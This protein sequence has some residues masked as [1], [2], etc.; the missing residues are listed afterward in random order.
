MRDK[1]ISLLDRLLVTHSPSGEEGE[2]EGIVEEL[3][4]GCC[5]SV[6]RDP[7]DNIMAKI[8][9]R[10]SEDATLV[11]AHKDEIGAIVHTIDD[12]GLLRLE[13]LG[14]CVPW[15]YGEGPW[16]VLGDEVITG[17][18]SVGSKHSTGESPQ[19]AAAKAGNLHW[20][21]CYIDCKLSK[22]EL[23]AK[24]VR[25]GTRACVARSRKT[26]MLLGDCI[27]GYALDDKASVAM[28]VLLAR[29]IHESGLRP[30][31][32]LYLAATS[33]EE[34]GISGGAYAAAH[35]P[36][37]EAIALEIAPV[38]PEYPI[39]MSDQP[40]IFYKDAIFVYHK[41]LSDRLCFTG[42]N[43]GLECQPMLVRS[44]GSDVSTAVKYGHIGRAACVGFPTEN[45]HGYEIGHLGAMENCVKLL[46][47]YLMGG[48]G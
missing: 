35:V 27:A 46:Q 32:D 29:A 2:M 1:L 25:V 5:D 16:D 24:G 43:L 9:G 39:M 18:L 42:K 3:L 47:A 41:G 10:S 23:A 28:M 13:P 33:N 48:G 36:A 17:I 6:W 22:D 14:G 4:Q 21:L 44:F 40:V 26:P 7:H 30:A 12:K 31:R 38:A 34:P 37:S 19:I 8:E 45:T 15:A 11:L 20:G